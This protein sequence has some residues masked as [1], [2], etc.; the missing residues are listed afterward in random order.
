M[1]FRRKERCVLSTIQQQGSIRKLM[2]PTIHVHRG[3]WSLPVAVLLDMFMGM[4][5]EMRRAH[6][7]LVMRAIPRR[8][9]IGQLQRND[10][11]HQQS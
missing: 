6:T 8:D 4:M 5:T 2:Q 7:V 11:E 10:A 3:A 1:A 9:G